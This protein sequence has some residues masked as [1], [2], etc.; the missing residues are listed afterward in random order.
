MQ[1]NRTE[2]LAVLK[3][4]LPAVVTNGVIPQTDCFFFNDSEHEIITYNDEIA[5]RTQ[6][7]H[8]IGGAVD[9]KKLVAVLDRMKDDEVTI[10]TDENE[11][12][13][14]GKR[15]SSG[16]LLEREITAPID[17]I[18]TPKN[19]SSL[20]D[21]F[22]DALLKTAAAAA[23]DMTQP[24]LS[25]VHITPKHLEAT[26][27]KRLTRVTIETE[28]PDETELLLP[29]K[30]AKVITDV[31]PSAFAFDDAWVHFVS[32][33]VTVSVRLI[34]SDGRF[35]DCGR[36]IESS[37]GGE[38]LTLPDEMPEML[39]RASALF[40]NSD[41]MPSVTVS[42]SDKGALKIESKTAHGW[43][44]ETKRVK[45]GGGAL[46]FCA[47]PK[48]LSDMLALSPVIT[49]KGDML[50]LDAEN[51]VHIAMMVKKKV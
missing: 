3:S 6:F 14:L 9:A 37:G 44:K 38:T 19:P 8:D 31:E 36:I 18:P 35:P 47:Q 33:D 49:V 12:R 24:I 41:L 29:A 30:W 27:G 20:P 43:T 15:A 28:L 17:K 51:I 23:D 4:L 1:T 25:A 42:V 40:D 5:I 32:E 10:E 11:L 2:F 45:H 34:T 50:R 7:D 22:T 46:E 16:I 13:V 21:G 48:F 39:A 26:D